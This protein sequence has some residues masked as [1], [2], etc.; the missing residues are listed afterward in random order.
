M[1]SVGTALVCATDVDML[2]KSMFC[3]DWLFTGDEEADVTEI[4]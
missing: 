2:E 3:V 1:F 4:N